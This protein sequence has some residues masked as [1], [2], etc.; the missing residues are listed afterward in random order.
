MTTARQPE[1]S[2][3]MTL[4]PCPR[5]KLQP[6]SQAWPTPWLQEITIADGLQSVH[7]L[8]C[9]RPAC[10]FAE[11]VG[12]RSSDITT[13][14]R[15]AWLRTAIARHPLTFAAAAIVNGVAVGLVLALT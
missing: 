3:R 2:Y 13:P 9:R 14:V 12:L 6:G 11:I 1:H 15:H 10:H 5:C 7:A 4:T 8:V